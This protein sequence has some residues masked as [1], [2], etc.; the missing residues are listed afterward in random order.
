M[1]TYGASNARGYG[2]GIV[3]E[4]LEGIGVEHSLKLGFQASN[5]KTKY[6]ALVVELRALTT[7]GAIDV[8]IYFGLRLVVSQV[9]GDFKTKDSRMVDYLKLVRSLQAQFRSMKVT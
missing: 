4:S 8:E 7:V 1:S 9:K 2:I 5:N 6:E 3:L